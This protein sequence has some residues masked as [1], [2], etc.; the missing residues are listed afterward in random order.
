MNKKI[1]MTYGSHAG[2]TAGVA[3][4]IAKTLSENGDVVEIK[5]VENIRNIAGIQCGGDRD[6]Y[7]G[8]AGKK[9][10]K[11]LCRPQS[12]GPKRGAGRIVC[13]VP[14][15]ERRHAREPAQKSAWLRPLKTGFVPAGEGLFAGKVEFAK[16][17]LFARFILEKMAK[18]PEGD[19]TDRDA[20]RAWAKQMA[21]K[22]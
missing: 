1:L 13:R 2:S 20:V 4:A 14:D 18:L 17:G 9:L 21:E 7:Q 11:R 19:Y 8:R 3:D 6:K 16:L 22:L 15:N 12:A 5:P 10:C